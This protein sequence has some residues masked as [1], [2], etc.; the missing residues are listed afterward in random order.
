MQ[1]IKKRRDATQEQKIE[2]KL[3]LQG[4]VI[5]SLYAHASFQT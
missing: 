5:K 2:K 4:Q 3:D 1:I